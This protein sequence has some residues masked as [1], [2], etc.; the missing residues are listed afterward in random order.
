LR[1][2]TLRKR[3]LSMIRREPVDGDHGFVVRRMDMEK[4]L[5]GATQVTH[6]DR[7]NPKL[8]TVPYEL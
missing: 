1:D 2:Y 8:N 3:S 7:R 6:E 4:A 5:R